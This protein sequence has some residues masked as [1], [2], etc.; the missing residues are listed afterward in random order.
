MFHAGI[1]MILSGKSAA[2]TL[3][4]TGGQLRGITKKKKI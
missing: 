2:E 3:E 4:Y 1:D